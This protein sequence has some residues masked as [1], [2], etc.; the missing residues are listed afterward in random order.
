MLAIR[1]DVHSWYVTLVMAVSRNKGLLQINAKPPALEQESGNLLAGTQQVASR[2]RAGADKS[3]KRKINLQTRCYL[4][5]ALALLVGLG[6]SA[7]IYLTAADA[8]ENLLGYDVEESKMY[9]HDLE[10]YGGKAN[11]LAAEIMRWLKGLWHGKP[12]AYTVGCIAMLISLG[13]FFVAHHS[14]PD[15]ESG[16]RDE[17]EQDGAE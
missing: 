15:V 12:L 11:V 4:G 13:L 1:G 7:I 2:T 14:P 8:P 9:L 3:M 16:D 5:S 17:S 6:A 10:L